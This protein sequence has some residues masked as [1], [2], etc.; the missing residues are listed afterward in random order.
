MPDFTNKVALITG[1]ARGQGRETALAL[2][3]EG[4]AVVAFDVGVKI[5]YP[6]YSQAADAELES[7]RA[8]IEALGGRCLA[9]VGDVRDDAA[10]TAAVEAAVAAFGKIDILFNNAGICAYAEADRMTDEEWDAMIDINLKGPFNVARRVIPHLKEQKSGV[11]INNSSVMG[12][13]GGRRL[14]HYVASKWGLTGLTK[15]WA[16]ELAPWNIRVVSIHPTGVNT[17]MNDGLAAL[18][19]KT[20]TEIAEASAGNLQPVPWI[21]PED[22][23]QLVLYLASDRARYATGSQFVLDAGLLS[24]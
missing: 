23:A 3:K 11:I 13:R 7:L 22:V 14:S 2:A 1:A 12:L 16:I 17:P 9:A 20:P 5:A 8:E 10:V 24:V 19:G 21:E 4:A 18:E 15:A 6:A